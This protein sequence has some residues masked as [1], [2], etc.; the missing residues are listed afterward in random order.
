VLLV[1][2]KNAKANTSPAA[3]SACLV[4][5]FVCFTDVQLF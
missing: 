5:P 1:C 4:V 2:P 3:T